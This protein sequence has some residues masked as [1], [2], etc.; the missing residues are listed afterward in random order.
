MIRLLPLACAIIVASPAADT[1]SVNTP[2]IAVRADGAA[3]PVPTVW[4]IDGYHGGI[5]GHMPPGCMLDILNELDRK[6]WWKASLEIEPFSWD[7]LKSRDPRA[8]SR[9]QTMLLDRGPAPRIEIVSGSYSQPFCWA[10]GGES[11]IRQLQMGI[12]ENRRHFKDLAITTYAVQEPCYTSA[13][14]QILRSL[15]YERA[16]LKN[17]TCWGG[18]IAGKFNESAVQWTGPDGSKIPATVRYACEG[19]DGCWSPISI[20]PTAD[21]ARMFAKNGILFPTGT[22]FQDAGWPAHPMVTGTGENTGPHPK[23]AD[24][25]AWMGDSVHGAHVRFV[26]YR[27]LFSTIMPAPTTAWNLTQEDIRVALPWGAAELRELAQAVHSAEKRIVRA[28]KLSA[29][30]WL[31]AGSAWPDAALAQ[32]WKD[33]LLAQHHDSWIVSSG[34]YGRRRDTWAEQSKTLSWNVERACEKMEMAA[35]T[36]MAQGDPRGPADTSMFL[37]VC[38][39][40]AIERSDLAQTLV[41]FNRGYRGMRV[42]DAQNNPVPCQFKANRTYSDGTINAVSLLFSAR[43]PPTGYATFRIIPLTEPDSSRAGVRAHASESGVVTVES[44]LYRIEIDPALGGTL[45]S[46]ICKSSGAEMIDTLLARKFGELR[47]YFTEKKQW[48]SSADSRAEIRIEENGPVR[49]AVQ[50]RG[51]INGNRITTRMVVVQG[52]RRI[53]FSTRI[54]FDQETRIGEEWGDSNT[55]ASARRPCY[56]DRFKLQVL[57]PTRLTSCEVNKDA[58]FDVCKSVLDNT[59]FNTWDS[60][61]NNVVLNWVDTYDPKASRGLSLFCDHTTSYALGDSVPLGLVLAFSGKG[62]WNHTFTIKGP[63]EARYAIVPHAGEWDSSLIWAENMQ[64][65]EPLVAQVIS[66]TPRA[67]AGRSLVSLDDARIDISAM[68]VDGNALMVRLFNASPAGRGATV[69]FG[70]PLRAADIVELD[71]RVVKRLPLKRDRAGASATVD[72]PPFGI[73]T[74]RVAPGKRG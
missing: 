42:L 53:D 59:F 7:F 10:I 71:G 41:V 35:S 31:C 24:T 46:L 44:D 30:A 40:T 29:M 72:F 54:A 2:G 70:F 60:I 56:D 65:A 34:K 74:I 37:R 58:A 12:A 8:Y 55:E 4:F 27:E 17:F 26:T 33:L 23:K 3:A 11:N 73:R 25:I 50:I 20:H 22:T 13:L 39:T 51:A 67:G 6:P 5:E 45:R 52:C 16:A 21:I 9:L 61:K 18:Y 36:A 64:W 15:G 28:E 69:R 32:A 49:A 63:V 19:F 62:L 43:V 47:G 66:N 57:F 48:C 68:T 1:L 14:P 38:N